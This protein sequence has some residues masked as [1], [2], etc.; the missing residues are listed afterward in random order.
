MPDA[1]TK[2]RV[3]VCGLAIEDGRVL[4]VNHRRFHGNPTFPETAWILP[5]GAIELGEPMPAAVRR[6]VKEETGLDCEVGE[7]LFIKE[8]IYPF[9]ASPFPNDSLSGA[10]ADAPL[11]LHSLSIG[12]A[13]RITGGDLVT[14]SDPEV[15]GEQLI[16]ESRWLPVQELENRTLYPPFLTGYI[17]AFP[18]GAPH[19]RYIGSRE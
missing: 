5:G 12:F 19:L 11:E 17:R 16:I 15:S 6:E 1:V 9:P 2:I 4:L 7:L 10:A 3:R 8:L 13:C 18:S 14:G